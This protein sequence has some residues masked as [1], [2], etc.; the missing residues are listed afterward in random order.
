[1]HCG[2][3]MSAKAAI[4]MALYDLIGQRLGVPL[5]QLL[6]LN[7]ERT[8]HTSFTIGIDTPEVMARSARE[9]SEYPVLKIKLGTPNDLEIV[10]AIRDATN[11]T[12]RVDAN[13]A[14]TPK[15]AVRAINALE[16]FNIEFVEQPVAA[17][18]SRRASL[19][20]RTYLAAD[21]R[22]RKLCDPFGCR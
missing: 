20:A 18:R 7:P 19:R 1:M 3:N 22:G 14:W 6:G 13:A 5:Y 12:L 4:E 21:Y 10:R 11:A 17:Q 16:P 15:E 8:P 9:A 2:G